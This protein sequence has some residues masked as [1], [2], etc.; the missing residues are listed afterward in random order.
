[1]VLPTATALLISPS[2]SSVRHFDKGP[3]IIDLDPATHSWAAIG[4]DLDGS[5]WLKTILDKVGGWGATLKKSRS[6]SG[7]LGWVLTY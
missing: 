7:I 1:M 3:I 2:T 5:A 6:I 4:L